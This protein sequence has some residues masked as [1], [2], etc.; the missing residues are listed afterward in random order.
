M[1]GSAPGDLSWWGLMGVAG[2]CKHA[3]AGMQVYKGWCVWG[4]RVH[5]CAASMYTK[6]VLVFL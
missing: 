5:R 3:C 4:T 1:L 2:V 6:R